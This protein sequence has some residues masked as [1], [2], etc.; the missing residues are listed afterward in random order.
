MGKRMAKRSEPADME[1]RLERVASAFDAEDFE[2]VLAQAEALLS[3][4]PGQP[5]AL[6]YSKIER[7]I[8]CVVGR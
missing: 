6:H 5:E 4:A 1:E 3:E 7:L 8:E 2:G